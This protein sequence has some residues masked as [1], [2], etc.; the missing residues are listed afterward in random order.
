MLRLLRWLTPVI[1][2]ISFVLFYFGSLEVDKQHLLA[3]T[4]KELL[5]NIQKDSAIIIHFINSENDRTILSGL[6]DSPLSAEVFKGDSIIYWNKS[7]CTEQKEN[8]DFVQLQTVDDSVTSGR[9]KLNLEAYNKFLVSNCISLTNNPKA[10]Q[11][12]IFGQ[13]IGLTFNKISIYPNALAGAWWALFFA[14]LTF[15]ILQIKILKSNISQSRDIKAP[16]IYLFGSLIIFKALHYFDGFLEYMDNFEFIKNINPSSITTQSI[17]HLMINIWIFGVIIYL[18]TIALPKVKSFIPNFKI[19]IVFSAFYTLVIFGLSIGM[20]E[21]F[22]LSPQVN[23]EIESLMEFNMISFVLIICFI[24]LMILIFQSS[25]MLF[26]LQNAQ[27]IQ[28]LRKLV[29]NLAGW[30]LGLGVLLTFSHLHVPIWIFCIFI[31]SYTLIL[32]AY[33]DNK[34]KKITYLIWWLIMFSGFL[35]VVLFYFGLKKDIAE[36]TDFLDRYYAQSDDKMIQSMIALQDTLLKRDVFNRIASLEYS[37]RLDMKDLY[38]Y[39]F[40]KT[41]QSNRDR[42]DISIELFDRN[43]GATLFN[44]HFADY[45]KLNQSY[46]NARKV[47]RQVYHNPF[48]DKYIT[49]LEVLRQYPSNA[50]WYLFIIS[51]QKNKEKSNQPEV[52]K[53]GYAVFSKGKLIEKSDNNQAAP[54]LSK[55]IA[56]NT[57]KISDGYSFVISSPSDQYKIISWKKVSGLIKPISLFSFIFTLC[58]ILI[59]I[60]SLINT[61]YDFLPENISLKFGSRSSLKTK[62]QLAIILLI[63]VTFLTIGAITAIYFKN[64]IEANQT[65]KHKEETMSITNNIRSDIQNFVDDEYAL[66]FLNSKLKDLSYIHDKELSLYDASGKLISSTATDQIS[67]RI[68]Y[69]SWLSAIERSNTQVLIQNHDKR[70]YIPLYLNEAHAF[71]YIGIDHMAYSTSSGNILDFLSTIL[72]AY[73]FLFLIAGAIAITIANSITQPLTILAEKLKK[74]KLGK[75]NEQLE[76][77]SNDEIGTL[78]H[79]YN[80]LTHELERSAG[81]LAKTERDMAWRE[82]AKQVAHE[83]KNPLTPMNIRKKRRN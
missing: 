35:A 47:G 51:E 6:D 13:N 50:S 24:I 44:N 34:E 38:Q 57:N 72:N 45:Y 79:D 43:T 2:F 7:A 8:V 67:M 29:F 83:I 77:N 4:K 56:V 20:I 61:K 55:L 31:V 78:I 28:P 63:L 80:N 52:P 12:N 25:Q 71:A 9:I 65:I 10:D 59:M 5:T 70:E 26:E 15:S 41:M 39:M 54:D 14:I 17:A 68:P 53:Y 19:L 60:L 75:S 76:W 58:G 27:K 69:Q 66:T 23:L 32:D 3:K 73:I 16:L 74:F 1:L 33:T 64:L 18:V 42:S 11:I 62:I 49:R 46:L 81:L 40:D 37:S 82:M 21:G 36:R 48:E 30:G 22:V